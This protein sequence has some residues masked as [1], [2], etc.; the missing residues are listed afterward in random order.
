MVDADLSLPSKVVG[1]A[2]MLGLAARNW[3]AMR[4]S[5]FA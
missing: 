2:R 4:K 3:Q 5:F 1:Y